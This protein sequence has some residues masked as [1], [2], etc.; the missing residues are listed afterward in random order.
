MNEKLYRSEEG[1]IIGGVCSGLAE[2]FKSDVWII[3]IIFIISSFFGAVGIILY[4]ILWVILPE[5]NMPNEENHNT[6]HS[7]DDHFHSDHL[8][9]KRMHARGAVG[10]FLILVGALF[11]LNNLFPNVEIGKYWPVILIFLGAAI[12]L[13]TEA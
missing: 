13:R 5:K 4:L 2:Y 7:A 12:M 3:R 1:R 11:L 6:H 9:H 8:R 10:F